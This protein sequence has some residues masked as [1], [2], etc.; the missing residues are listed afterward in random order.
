[1]ENYDWG[2]NQKINGK[3]FNTDGEIYFSNWSLEEDLSLLNAM[4]RCGTDDW[5][6]ISQYLKNR[7]PLEC[8]LHYMYFFFLFPR[9]PE[10]EYSEILRNNS[11]KHLYYNTRQN[12]NISN[13]VVYGIKRSNLTINSGIDNNHGEERNTCISK[14][15]N[16]VMP[17]SVDSV[18]GSLLGKRICEFDEKVVQQPLHL[19]IK[20]DITEPPRI[21][22]NS[23]MAGYNPYRSD[24]HTEYDNN[25]E[26]VLSLLNYDYQNS[27]YNYYNNS[28]NF[29]AAK[30]NENNDEVN[31]IKELSVKIIEGYN[32]RLQER[33][34]RK[35]IIR[36]YGLINPRKII[37]YQSRLEVSNTVFCC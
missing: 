10:L 25:A 7:T 16:S 12:V 22:N 26:D 30:I 35:Q 21:L 19:N 20:L 5:L 17:F 11:I 9:T 32:L 6:Q 24:F 29:E 15:D 2:E 4:E 1:M 13:S 23:L 34:K 14:I 28:V 27:S 31:L 18:C 33:K 8:K 37:G 3:M 36:N